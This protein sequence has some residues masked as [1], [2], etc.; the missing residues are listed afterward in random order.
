MFSDAFQWYFPTPPTGDYLTVIVDLPRPLSRGEVKLNSANP[1]DAPNIK[2][3]I[4]SNELDLIAIR[5]GVRWV[6]EVLMK[7]EGRKDIIAEDYPLAHASC[8]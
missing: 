2:L 5:E 1:R 3:G 4:F 7:G 8:F 6:D